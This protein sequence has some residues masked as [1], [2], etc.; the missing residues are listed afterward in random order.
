[1][2]FRRAENVFIVAIMEV[3]TL[4]AILLYLKAFYILVSIPI[5]PNKNYAE[6]AIND[7]KWKFK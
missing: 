7:W 4:I 3:Y 1:L 2:Y 6:L 5:G